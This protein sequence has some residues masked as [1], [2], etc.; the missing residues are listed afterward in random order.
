MQ[1]PTS[2]TFPRTIGIDLG[3]RKSAFCI[4]SPA[5]ERLVED[6]LKT[7][8]P[9]MR[10]F[11]Q[12][13]PSS[14]VVIEAS[15][16]S[17]WVAELATSCGHDVLV[18]N[19]REFRLICESHRKTDRNDSRILA[20]FGQFRPQLLHPVKLRGLECHLARTLIAARAHLVRQRTLT[21]NFIRAQVR[22][23]GESLPVCSAA[24]FHK[25]A[26]ELI[27]VKLRS[28]LAPMQQ[29]LELLSDTIKNYDHEI[30]CLCREEFP[31][32]AIL[33]Q[34]NG[35]GPN[36]A[37]AFI[38]TIED[39]A[40]FACSRNVGAYVGLVSKSRSS[41][42]KDP[43]LRISKRGDK[44]LRRLLV[45][46]ATYI[47]GPRGQDSDLKR[48]GEHLQERGGQASRAKARIAVARKLAV[49]LHRLWVTG[50]VYEPLHNSAVATA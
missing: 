7:A 36:T 44:T 47:V 9:E 46:A 13:Q 21:I 22:N 42:S 23:L 40:R 17:R 2:T 32:T 20:D 3:I 18:A 25:K 43:Q 33:S 15:G 11:L 50:E 26:Q 5:G 41:G 10:S 29:S 39:P 16:P 45:N 1:Q 30:E 8:Q 35:V 37:L 38:A 28:S 49:L 48:Y 14:R 27:P 4:V 34:V 24:Y 6:E 19:P 31:E 12:S